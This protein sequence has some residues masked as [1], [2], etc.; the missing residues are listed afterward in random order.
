M[1]G[2]GLVTSRRRHI[3]KKD[4]GSLRTSRVNEVLREIIADEL[5]RIDDE[6]QYVHRQT[7]SPGYECGIGLSDFQDLKDGD[8]IETFEEREIARTISS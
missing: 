2:V 3:P 5:T 8:V 4:F 6:R 7:P 1:D